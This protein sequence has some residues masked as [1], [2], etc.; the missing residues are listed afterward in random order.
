MKTKLITAIL[1]LFSLGYNPV[2]AQKKTWKAPTS[3]DELKNPYAGDEAATQ[4]GKKL[5]NQMCALC[6]GL[7]GK[8]DG[9]A[10][11]NLDPHPSNFHDISVK[12]E[13]D[14]AIFWKITH[15]NPPMASYEEILSEEQRWDLV[16]YIRALEKSK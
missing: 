1:I 2:L 3:A 11:A 9:M 15:G 10:G 6:H 5:F 16:N 8:G 12:D 7:K 4:K 13:S 14:G